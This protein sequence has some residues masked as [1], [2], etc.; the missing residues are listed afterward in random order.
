M[1]SIM[2][3]VMTAAT[4]RTMNSVSCTCSN[5]LAAAAVSV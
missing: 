4:P 5:D 2:R 1:K 3:I